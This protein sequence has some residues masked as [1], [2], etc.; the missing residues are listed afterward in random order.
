MLD[1]LLT[2]RTSSPTSRWYK[3]YPDRR[4]IITV[5]GIYAH[6]VRAKSSSRLIARIASYA[7]NLA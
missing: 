7:A 5:T 3:C 6:R 4:W 2:K 1:A